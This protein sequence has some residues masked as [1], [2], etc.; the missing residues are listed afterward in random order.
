VTRSV[1]VLAGGRSRRLGRD[2]AWVEVGGAPV[3]ARVLRAAREALATDDPDLLVS[4]TDAAPFEARFSVDLANEFAGVRLIE[5]DVSGAGPVAGLARGLAAARGD[6]VAVLAADLPFV[7]AA[8][9]DGLFRSLAGDD[10]V[11]VV[12][13]L[14]DGREQLLCAGYRASVAARAADLM[15]GLSAG[16]SG[17]SVAALL[18][19]LHV[20]RVVTVAALSPGE[21]AI[22]CRGIDTPADLAW[23]HEEA[24]RRG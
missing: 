15:A 18:H 9:I 13:P 4:V 12:V 23:A 17:P 20:S 11:D 10:A 3:L 1:L 21:L 6:V 24:A 19:T 7:G 22:Q 16:P 8:L 14:V 2:K 5:D